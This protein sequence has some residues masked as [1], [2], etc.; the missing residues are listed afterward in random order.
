LSLW[1]LVELLKPK[2]YYE[3]FLFINKS[4]VLH[5]CSYFVYNT[6]L[7]FFEIVGGDA[8]NHIFSRLGAIVWAVLGTGFVILAG[9]FE[10]SIKDS[11]LKKIEAF[12]RLKQSKTFLDLGI[13]SEAEFQLI[14]KKLSEIIRPNTNLPFIKHGEV[15]S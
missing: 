4:C 11:E 3:N 8:Y 7:E 5:H 6:H 10:P 12:E 15:W 13:I 9:Y 2:F 14:H 1:V